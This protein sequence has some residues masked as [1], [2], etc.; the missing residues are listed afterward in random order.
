MFADD[1]NLFIFDSNIETLFE[2]MNEELRK[3]A[4]LFKANKLSLNISKTKYSF[5]HSTRKRIDIPNIFPSLHIDNV[6]VKRKFV[7]SFLVYT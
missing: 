5:L 4:N 6:S 3:L 7:T 1:T 2:T